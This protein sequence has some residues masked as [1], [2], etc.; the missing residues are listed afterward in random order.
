MRRNLRL[1]LFKIDQGSI[2]TYFQSH[3]LQQK[4]RNHF[5]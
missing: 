4:A 5:Y 1:E 2:E 3:T